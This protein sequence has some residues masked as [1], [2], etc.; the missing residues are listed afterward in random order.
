MMLYHLF[1]NSSPGSPIYPIF[2]PIPYVLL[3]A[4]ER[5][6]RPIIMANTAHHEISNLIP[7]IWPTMVTIPQMRT[8][9]PIRSGQKWNCI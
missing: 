2:K 1:G 4:C 6:Q 8:S 7:N 5:I 3:I 9:A